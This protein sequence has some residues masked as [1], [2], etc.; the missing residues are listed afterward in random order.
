MPRQKRKKETFSTYYILQQTK[1]NKLFQNKQ[2]K[3][4]FLDILYKTKNNYGY[5]LYAYCLNKKSYQLII[6]DNGNDISKIM[7][8]INVSLTMRLNNLRNSKGSLF[9]E[10]F[11]SK[12][13]KDGNN[14]IKISKKIHK[15]NQNSSY[16]SYCAYFKNNKNNLIDKDVIINLIKHKN[17]YT[18]Y[19]K[20][21]N[22]EIKTIKCFCEIDCSKE[23][24][25]C[26]NDLKAAK[27]FL[28][29]KLNKEKITYKQLLNNKSLRNE[30]IKQ[31]RK[32]SIL[33]LEELGKLFGGLS[34]SSIS[35]IINK[36][37]D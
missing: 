33:T 6:Y 19:K 29:Q 32:K 24:R 11:K 13:I 22:D 26:I 17:K 3:E 21:I 5:K 18:V 2:D 16:N 20:Y 31:M 10:R 37:G 1:S 23:K 30:F 35:K 7:K 12:K 4:L 15:N 8:S 34:S 27:K 25:E 36:E 9:T 28:K 14:L